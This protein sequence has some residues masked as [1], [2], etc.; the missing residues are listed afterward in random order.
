MAVI[1][2]AGGNVSYDWEYAD[3][4]AIPNRM[5]SL[6]RPRWLV[7]RLGLDYFGFV[8]KVQSV[9]PGNR[10]SELESIA[11][12]GRLEELQLGG[13]LVTD[14]SLRHLT[15][16]VNLQ[17]LDLSSCDL[18]DQGLIHLRGLTSLKMLDLK[19]TWVTDAGLAHLKGLTNLQMLNLEET[20][21][22]DAGVRDLKLALP[23][24]YIRH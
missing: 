13:F 24:T 23:E 8:T 22:S 14:S 12:L 10:D 3:G 2:R 20:E 7:K 11:S 1:K 6:P 4:H 5:Q 21:V 17:I 16:M 19:R 18:T 9:S 15:G